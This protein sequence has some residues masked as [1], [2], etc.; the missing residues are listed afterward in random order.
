MLNGVRTP[1]VSSLAWGR[2]WG[3]WG[4]LFLLNYLL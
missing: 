1:S 4:L 2:A 3:F